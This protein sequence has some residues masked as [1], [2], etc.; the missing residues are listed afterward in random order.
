MNSPIAVRRNWELLRCRL[1]WVLVVAALGIA[2]P[3]VTVAD[4]SALQ[5]CGAIEDS[6][7]RLRCYDEVATKVS[8][9]EA[10]AANDAALPETGAQVEATGE[11]PGEQQAEAVPEP[12]SQ[13]QAEE[14]QEDDDSYSIEVIRCERAPDDRHYF[15]FANGQVWKQA[16]ADRERYKDCNFTVTVMRDWFGYKMQREGEERRVRI[17]LVK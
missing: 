15:Y 10:A 17:A 8:G 16:K 14:E 12:Q 5:R 13:P 7:A 1:L 3:C 9:A 4:E 11:P 2:T 6:E